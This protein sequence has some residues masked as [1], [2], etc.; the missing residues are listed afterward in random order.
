MISSHFVTHEFFIIYIVKHSYFLKIQKHFTFEYKAY[1]CLFSN[2]L[3][4]YFILHNIYIFNIQFIHISYCMAY[5][6]E[7]YDI[8][9]LTNYK[10]IIL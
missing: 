8:D 10:D 7:K 2:I 4:V 5:I 9:T 1:K 6:M 3:Q